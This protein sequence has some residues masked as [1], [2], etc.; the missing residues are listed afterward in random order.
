VRSTNHRP[1]RD[2][3]SSIW[4]SSVLAARLLRPAPRVPPGDTLRDGRHL[5]NDLDG[6]MPCLPGHIAIPRPQ[7]HASCKTAAPCMC[8]LPCVPALLPVPVY[9][10]RKYGM[11][12]RMLRLSLWAY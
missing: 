4:S 10:R 3:G 9:V 5:P 12:V 11:R 8:P 6:W 1:R 2:R 7:L